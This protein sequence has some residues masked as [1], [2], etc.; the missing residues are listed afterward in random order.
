MSEPE[1][2]DTPAGPAQ[3][4]RSKRKTLAISVLPDGKLELA[5]PLR[6]PLGAIIEKVQKR[7]GWIRTQRRK[8][9]EMNG[10]RPAP[11]HV[12][13][14]THRY[15]GRQYRLKVTTGTP[16]KVTL[17]GAWLI[18]QVAHRTEDRVRNALNGWC[19]QRA[20][21]QFAR[22][23]AVWAEWCAHHGLPA[24]RPRLRVMK[25]RWGSASQTGIILL[26]PE[27]VR[28]PSACIDY[29]ITH[30]ICHLRHPDHGKPFH[31]LL[32]R[33]LPNWRILKARLEAGD[34]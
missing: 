20:E 11:R 23:V 25:K 3:L 29:V 22:R 7:T 2:I 18:V 14:A 16:A 12:A 21:E 26:N 13:G 31:R 10:R 27:L 5:A 32:D 34:P 28:A 15:L 4:K 1:L 8:F 33:L 19:R 30:E 24:P 9:H 6:A 17:R